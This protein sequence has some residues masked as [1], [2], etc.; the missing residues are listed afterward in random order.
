MDHPFFYLESCCHQHV[1]QQVQ[2]RP[3]RPQIVGGRMVGVHPEAQILLP[4]SEEKNI[5]LFT[6]ESQDWRQKCKFDV[7]NASTMDSPA[8]WQQV[9]PPVG[10]V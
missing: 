10:L 9:V 5:L 4:P 7:C 8:H 2:V 1:V 3:R 6:F